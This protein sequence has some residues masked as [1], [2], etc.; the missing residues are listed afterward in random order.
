VSS[1]ESASVLP[2]HRTL[3]ERVA[4]RARG[5]LQALGVQTWGTKSFEF[6]TLLAATLW[7]VRPRSILELGSGRS[8]SYLGDY[9]QKEDAIFVSIEQ[10]RRFAR[11]MRLGLRAGFVDPRFV[12]HVPL[13]GEWYDLERVQALAPQP[14]ELM[15]VDG[16]VG[17]QESLGQATRTDPDAVDWLRSIA[18]EWHALV[19][20]DLQRPDNVRLADE[21]LAAGSVEP[22]YLD[23]AP[24]PG[25]RNVC[26]V[27]V[28]P[29]HA[30]ALRSACSELALAVYADLPPAKN[31]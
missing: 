16:P 24:Q 28:A 23:Y 10:N 19:I 8:T 7:L 2:R 29:D 12:R 5:G 1:T 9:A 3:S 18:P 26:M 6:W 17:K 20:D 22:C 4:G 14:C 31:P 15:F 13:R 27:A 30:A 11:R 21:L 25:V